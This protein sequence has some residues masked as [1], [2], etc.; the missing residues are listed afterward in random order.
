MVKMQIAISFHLQLTKQLLGLCPNMQVLR[1]SW[2]IGGH[3]TCRP[4][5]YFN[6]VSNRY[7]NW[8]YRMYYPILVTYVYWF[9]SLFLS[10]AWQQRKAKATPVSPSIIGRMA[11]RGGLLSSLTLFLVPININII[12]ISKLLLYNFEFIYPFVQGLVIT[13]IF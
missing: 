7:V 5:N 9:F 12:T 3:I 8:W 6:N 2:W 10:V 4:W 1:N 13:W 11:S